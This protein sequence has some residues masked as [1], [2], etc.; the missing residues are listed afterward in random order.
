MIFLFYEHCLRRFYISGVVTKLVY[1]PFL[2][3]TLS[4]DSA[5]KP[6]NVSIYLVESFLKPHDF[7]ETRASS[8]IYCQTNW[9]DKIVVNRFGVALQTKLISLMVHRK[10]L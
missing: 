6:S 2:K 7:E 10:N 1:F 5:T 3:R 9:A 8:T 4:Y